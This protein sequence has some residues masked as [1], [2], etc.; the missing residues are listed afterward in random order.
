MGMMKGQELS[1]AY[2]SADVFVMPSETET[3]GFVVLEAMASGVPVVAVAAGGLTDILTRPGETGL[4]YPPNDYAACVAH[5]QR[6]TEDEPARA[7]LGAAGRAEVEAFGWNAATRKIREQ[8]YVRAIRLARGKR[9]FWWLA[10]RVGS[11]RLWR[12]MVGSLA[13]FVAS[14]VS[15]LDYARPY[16]PPPAVAA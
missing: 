16:R 4:L 10:L 2:A 13:G 9:R 5:V 6:L 8:Q 15:A 12:A 7:A 11:V 14:L 1:E 3:L